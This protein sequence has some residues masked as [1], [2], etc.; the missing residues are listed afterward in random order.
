MHWFASATAIAICSLM[1]RDSVVPRALLSANQPSSTAGFLAIVRVMLVVMP[2]ATWTASSN[3]LALPVAV[4]GLIGLMR[5]IAVL[6]VS[7]AAG[8]PAGRRLGG[9]ARGRGMPAREGLPGWR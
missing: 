8:S 1:R 3:S 7:G 4:S 2:N 9:A 6:S 5:G